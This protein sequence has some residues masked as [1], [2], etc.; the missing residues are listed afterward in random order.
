[1]KHKTLRTAIHLTLLICA[2]SLMTVSLRAQEKSTRNTWAWN[3]SDNG[4][5]IEVKV[6][7]KVEFNDDYSDVAAI[8][9]DG[10]LRIYDSRG[11]RTIRLA[12]TRGS[13]GE[14]RRDYS[15]DGQSRSFDA[16]GQ[17]WLRAVL[18]QAVR[19]GGLD[20]TD[21]AA[22]ILKQQGTRGLVEEITYLKGDYVRRIYF[23]VLL[24]APGVSTAD[25]ESALRNASNTIKG[26]YERAQLLLQVARVFLAN[27]NLLP[28]Y[29]D[30]VNKTG[31]P[32]EHARV[33]SGAL[34][35][36]E[37]S[38]EALSAI[39][40]SAATIDSDYEKA[41][42]LVMGAERYQA[43]LSLRMDWL[44]AA[45]TIASDHEH[46]RALSGALR[47][48]EISV[49]ALSD[50]VQSAARIQS[51]YEKASFLI[52]ALGHYRSDARLRAA[53]LETA[54]TIGSEYERGRVQKQFEK[55]ISEFE[56]KSNKG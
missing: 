50:L 51:D 15:I 9:A 42:L 56:G 46:H 22:R 25:L 52:E 53:F 23:G 10:A 16:E 19:E 48:N 38:K 21:R 40:Q 12:I 47:P 6:E 45:R 11:P 41:N 8:P 24:S 32:Y 13:A 27:R 37:L 29:F 2:A 20:A 17:R 36:D 43:S 39:A 3:N 1:M 14:L 31:T 30:A 55:A 4:R 49:E 5:K 7:N 18:L 33:L 35:R 34:K 28:A 54:R 44:H 26:D